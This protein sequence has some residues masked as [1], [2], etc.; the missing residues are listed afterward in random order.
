MSNGEFNAG[1]TLR[2]TTIPSGGGRVEML[3]NAMLTYLFI[4]SALSRSYEPIRIL[5]AKVCNWYQARE[6]ALRG[7][8]T[9]RRSA[10]GDKLNC[11]GNLKILAGSLKSEK[12]EIF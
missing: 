3:L 2:G 5:K 8:S 9:L 12:I 1:V 11:S 7:V 4:N 10:S 6:N